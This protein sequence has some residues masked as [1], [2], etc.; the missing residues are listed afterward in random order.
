MAKQKAAPEA[1]KQ[2]VEATEPTM[3]LNLFVGNLNF[4]KSAPELKMGISDVF[5]KNDLAVVDVRIGVCQKFG[6][7][8]FESAEDLE[9]ALELTGL[10]VFGNEIKQEKT[11]EEDSKK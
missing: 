6:Y 4:S 9:K 11:K 7:L 5:A 2:N 10:K 8:D 3:T 1:K